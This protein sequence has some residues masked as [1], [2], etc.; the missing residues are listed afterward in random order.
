MRLLVN[1]RPSIHE[2]AYGR[3]LSILSIVQ[4]N[5]KANT[6]E[7]FYLLLSEG[8]IDFDTID[9]TWLV[10]VTHGGHDP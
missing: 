5:R 2:V 1:H 10:A 9:E 3:T 4:N 8:F 7:F 6:V